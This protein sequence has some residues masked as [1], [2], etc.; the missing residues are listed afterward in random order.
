MQGFRP[1]MQD[2]F[3]CSP[4][5]NIKGDTL[6]FFAV[7]DGHGHYGEVVSQYCAENFMS[8]FLN[9]K[10]LRTGKIMSSE[11][12]A[13]SLK[14]T[15]AKFD[16][17]LKQ[18][19]L[20]YTSPVPGEEK[21]KINF[22]FSGTTATMALI[23]NRH[24]IVANTG[25]S[26]TI[27]CSS[28]GVKFSTLDHNPGIGGEDKRIVA[29]G[30]RIHTTPSKHK[31]ILDPEAYTNLA[32]SRTLGDYGFKKSLTLPVE[33]Q[34]VTPIPDVTILQRDHASDEFLILASDGVFKSMSST[35]AVTFVHQ[36]M[37]ITD[38]LPTI[39]RDL[40]KMAYYSVSWCCA[41][42]FTQL[43]AL[44]LRSTNVCST[45]VSILFL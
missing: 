25:D 36:R 31:V 20:R 11:L 22:V 33:D 42:E 17:Q 9:R 16:A 7:F 26:R 35:E 24:I 10:S 40:I 30:G 15:F 14:K 41:S 5:E 1:H 13:S 38:D 27:L 28:G 12:L 43:G 19:A 37:M 6:G 8:D 2:D 3:A 21:N 44:P 18:A 32:V 34:I 45:S 39:C 23:F 29:A 4:S